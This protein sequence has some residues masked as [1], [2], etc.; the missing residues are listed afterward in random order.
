M[1]SPHALGW[2]TVLH[3]DALRLRPGWLKDIQLGSIFV[4]TSAEVG[5][6]TYP[7]LA[8]AVNRTLVIIC[9]GGERAMRLAQPRD[10]NQRA[11]YFIDGVSFEVDRGTAT[12]RRCEEDVQLGE[13][14]R[15]SGALT[16]CAAESHSQH[17]ADIAGTNSP[18]DGPPLIAFS[19]WDIVTDL[20]G[21]RHVLYHYT[22]QKLLMGPYNRE[23][24]EY[25]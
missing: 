16:L 12:H 5:D 6:E 15:L 25:E 11:G 18:D 14:V 1:T 17:L 4:P 13:I 10:L 20:R 3:M 9:L 8:G 21:G 19:R 7:F 23:T 24:D 2:E 22:G